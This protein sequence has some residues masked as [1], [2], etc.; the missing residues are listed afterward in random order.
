MS[1]ANLRLTSLDALRGFDMI[2]IIGLEQAMRG[3]CVLFP[4]GQDWWFKRQFHHVPWDG[5]AFYDTIFPH[6]PRLIAADGGVLVKY[7]A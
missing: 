5:L 4:G 7:A 3:L 2:W 1:S 6:T